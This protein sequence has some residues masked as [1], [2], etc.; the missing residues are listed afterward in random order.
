MREVREVRACRSSRWANCK[1]HHRPG[2]P[3]P[4]VQVF[5]KSPQAC[6]VL[7]LRST[8]ESHL[9]CVWTFG[10]DPNIGGIIPP[11]STSTFPSRALDHGPVRRSIRYGAAVLRGRRGQPKDKNWTGMDEEEGSPIFSSSQMYRTKSIPCHMTGHDTKQTLLDSRPGGVGKVN[12]DN[13]SPVGF[14]HGPR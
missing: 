12:T 4:K 9:R 6:Q 8:S 14:S 10:L 5:P 13:I 7:W 2:T 3:R 1:A 11:S